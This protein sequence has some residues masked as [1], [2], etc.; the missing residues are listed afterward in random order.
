M[1]FSIIIISYVH[2]SVYIHTYICIHTYLYIYVHANIQPTAS[3]QCCLYV[4]VLS[5]HHLRLYITHPCAHSLG[6]LILL[7]SALTDYLQCFIQGWGL[8]RILSSML[9]CQMVLSCRRSCS[10]SQRLWDFMGAVRCYIQRTLSHWRHSCSGSHNLS[11]ALPW[12]S[13]SLRYMGCVV[14]V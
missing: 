7:L 14:G 9:A 12:C 1:T 2:I 3:T 5:K 11:T 6:R 13:T 8:V 10:G 4:Y